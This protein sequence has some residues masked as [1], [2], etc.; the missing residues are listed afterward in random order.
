VNKLV[1]A[2]L[3]TFVGAVVLRDF[4]GRCRNLEFTIRIAIKRGGLLPASA[5]TA[6]ALATEAD[7]RLFRAVISDPIHVLHKHLP[8]E[9]KLGYNLRPCAHWLKFPCKRDLNFISLLLY[10]DN[11]VDYSSLLAVWC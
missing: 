6:A 5:T 4:C 11:V 7:Q 3:W 10:T 8:E 2:T 1:L 9:W